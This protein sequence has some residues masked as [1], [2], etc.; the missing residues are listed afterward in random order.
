M[1]AVVEKTDLRENEKHLSVMAQRAWWQGIG[2]GYDADVH[3]RGKR[4]A[5]DQHFFPPVWMI[6]LDVCQVKGK[7]RTSL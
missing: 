3:G 5:L 1:R 4:E 7:I 6:M 2:T